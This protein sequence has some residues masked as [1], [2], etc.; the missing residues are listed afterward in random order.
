MRCRH[1]HTEIASNALI[2]YRCG[3]AAAEA[4]SHAPVS[5]RRAPAWSLAALVAALMLA[6]LLV[7][8]VGGVSPSTVPPFVRW[9][10]VVVA[11]CV[12]LGRMIRRR[13]G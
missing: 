5:K 6:L 4:M 11:V 10:I 7:S 8:N 13:R 2:C 3:T 12:L 9:G 1:C